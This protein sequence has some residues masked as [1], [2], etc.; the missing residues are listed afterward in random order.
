[1]GLSGTTAIV[2][3]GETRLAKDP[4]NRDDM[5]E[6]ATAARLALEDA[7]LT[8]EDVDGLAILKPVTV[9][10]LEWVDDFVEYFRWPVRY[11][12][13]GYRGGGAGNA[14]VLYGA[15]AIHSGLCKNVLIVGGGVQNPKI[16][17][18]D[19]NKAQAISES[20]R[21][22]DRIYGTMFTNS[23]FALL[24]RR[25]MHEFGATDEQF[26]QVAVNAHYHSSMHPNSTFDTKLTTD[27][28]LGS[29]M[30]CDPLHLYEICRPCTGAMAMVL[31]SASAARSSKNAPVYVLG[32][33]QSIRGGMMNPAFRIDRT[34]TTSPSREASAQ[35][36]EMAGVDPRDIDTVQLY[37]P[38]TI[39]VPIELEDTG[40]CNKGEGARFIERNDVSFRGSLPLNTDGGQLGRGQ[41]GHAAS[42][43]HTVEAVKQL[44]RRA[45]GLQIN[46]AKKAL[47]LEQGGNMAEHCVLI[48][49]NEE[50]S[51]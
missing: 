19:N 3:Y 49:S 38:Y 34:I 50:G 12:D 17:M 26:A 46:G 39:S 31:T 51:K 7:G 29:R 20:F 28:V 8:K 45:G 47:T 14:V 33:G 32:G 44:M 25:Y 36:Y 30:V 4:G 21:D 43:M 9:G 48:L 18:E 40:F 24:K 5:S 1:M 35:A 10:I 11:L 15:M 23:G 42:I 2:G 16:F 22:F 37:D 6:Y 13:A 27:D 41:P